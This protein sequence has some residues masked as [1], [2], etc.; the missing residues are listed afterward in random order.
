[1]YYYHYFIAEIIPAWYAAQGVPLSFPFHIAVFSTIFY[2]WFMAVFIYLRTHHAG[3]IGLLLA[4]VPST[5]LSPFWIGNPM[6]ARGGMALGW[7]MIVI[8]AV[9]SLVM[10]GEKSDVDD[11]KWS[12][13]TFLPLLYLGP[14][15]MITAWIIF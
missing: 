5:M 10:Y 14:V 15:L 1:M 2:T 8:I 11:S 6:I 12:K 7:I 4:V 9:V 3:P 13:Y